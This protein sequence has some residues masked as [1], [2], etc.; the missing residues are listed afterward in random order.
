MQVRL[1]G[2]SNESG[3]VE[4]LYNNVWGTVCDDDWDITDAHVVCKQLGFASAIA[5]RGSAYY[6]NGSGPIWI[7]NVRCR[8]NEQYLMHCPHRG[9]GRSNCGHDQ[10]AGVECTGL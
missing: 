3:R 10:D 7:E 5:A 1:S 4:V 6:G 8:G 9:H 2:G